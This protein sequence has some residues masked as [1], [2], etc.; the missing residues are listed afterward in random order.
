M[1]TWW[2]KNSGTALFSLQIF[3]QN[4][5]SVVSRKYGRH[6][7]TMLFAQLDYLFL[8]QI[9][10]PCVTCVLVFWF[11]IQWNKQTEMERYQLYVHKRS[12]CKTVVEGGMWGWNSPHKLTGYNRCLIFNKAEWSMENKC[13]DRKMSRRCQIN[14]SSDFPSVIIAHDADAMML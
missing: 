7:K 13:R 8:C 3:S 1:Y 9:P 6:F 2:A 12:P 10:L 5:Y 11:K 14:W 4:S